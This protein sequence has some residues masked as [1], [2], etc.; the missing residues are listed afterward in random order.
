MKTTEQRTAEELQKGHHGAEEYWPW[1]RETAAYARL[2]NYIALS[3]TGE[4]VEGA[5]ELSRRSIRMSIESNGDLGP[6][7]ETTAY[8][9]L[10]TYRFR[11]GGKVREVSKVYAFGPDNQHTGQGDQARKVANERLAMDYARLREGSIRIEEK[12]FM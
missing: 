10:G 12:Y 9:L 8:L 3:R 5:V 1:P 4:K 2:E 7:M 6:G 11:V